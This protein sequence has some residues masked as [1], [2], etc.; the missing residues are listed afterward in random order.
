MFYSAV[1]K[2]SETATHNLWLSE[3]SFPNSSPEMP[4]RHLA[5]IGQLDPQRWMKTRGAGVWGTVLQGGTWDRLW[6]H[7]VLQRDQLRVLGETWSRFPW[8]ACRSLARRVERP[9]IE[10]SQS[11][12][13][14]LVGPKVKGRERPPGRDPGS[15]GGCS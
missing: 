5:H 11:R 7:V 8:K 4:R 15:L 9:E 14:G 2:R 3:Q 6:V 12:Q 1:Q 13:V 10:M